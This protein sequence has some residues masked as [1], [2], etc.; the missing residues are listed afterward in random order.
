[1]TETAPQ[2]EDVKKM[3]LSGG[4]GKYE[5][6]KFLFSSKELQAEKPFVLAALAISRLD[7]EKAEF[8]SKSFRQWLKRFREKNTGKQ[9][10][11]PSGSSAIP[12]A[13]TETGKKFQFTDPATLPKEEGSLIKFV[14]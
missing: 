14:K 2:I 12:A 3:F 5:F 6:L 1:M 7:I 13:K 8:N 11:S 4:K 9:Q 10:S